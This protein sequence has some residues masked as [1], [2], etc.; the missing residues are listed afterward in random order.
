MRR[1]LRETNPGSELKVGHGEML[2]GFYL[3]SFRGLTYEKLPS[4]VF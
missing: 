1:A 3:P 4:L 2:P